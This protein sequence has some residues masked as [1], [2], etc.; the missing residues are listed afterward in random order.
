M[1]MPYSVPLRV[2]MS[3][4]EKGKS[5]AR[6]EVSSVRH[7]ATAFR[8]RGS[9]E[10]SPSLCLKA[11]G[12]SLPRVAAKCPPARWVISLS[13]ASSLACRVMESDAWKSRSRPRCTSSRRRVTS[14]RAISASGDMVRPRLKERL[15]AD[16][17]RTFC[18]SSVLAACSAGIDPRWMDRSIG[19]PAA[20]RL[21]RKPGARDRGHLPRWRERAR[22]SPTRTSRRRISTSTGVSSSISAGVPPRAEA[23]ISIRR[24]LPLKGWT[25]R[26]ARASRP[27]SSSNRANSV[28]A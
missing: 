24:R 6:D 20:M 12:S 23:S 13:D 21:W 25:D 17:K 16:S 26:P 9:V 5:R 28:M 27:R 2:S 10:S 22:R 7:T 4:G 3:G 1:S 15:W 19:A 14:S 11:R 8:P 18:H